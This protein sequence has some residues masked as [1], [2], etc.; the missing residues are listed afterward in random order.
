MKPTEMNER[1]GGMLKKRRINKRF[2]GSEQI[3][4]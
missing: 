3:P 4:L 1:S 2:K